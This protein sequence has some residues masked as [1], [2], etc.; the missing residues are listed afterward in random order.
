M[1]T[2]CTTPKNLNNKKQQ[3]NM[4]NVFNVQHTT[5][6]HHK[7]ILNISSTVPMQLSSIDEWEHTYSKSYTH[8]CNH[9]PRK[10]MQQAKANEGQ[11]QHSWGWAGP[12]EVG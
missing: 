10:K 11:A 6:N 3:I 7:Y 8:P 9:L 5:S 1:D 12:S 2:S 4:I